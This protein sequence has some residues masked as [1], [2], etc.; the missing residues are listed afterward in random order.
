MRGA[1]S[2]GALALAAGA[3]A[4]IPDVR[5]KVDLRI[6]YRVEQDGPS[7]LRL[8]DSL[9]RVSVFALTFDLEPGLKAVTS[10]RLERLPGTGDR[11][12]FDEFYVEDAGIWRAGKQYLPFG[13]GDLLRETVLAVRGDTPLLLRNVPLTFAAFDGG[14]GRTRGVMVRAGNLLNFSVAT[15]Q[16]LAIQSTS[17][18]PV[19]LPSEAPGRGRG[20]ERAYGVSLDQPIGKGF[21]RAEYV[22]LRQGE[23]VKD[24]DRDVLDVT[25]RERQNA[26]EYWLV[27]WTRDTAPARVWVRAEGAF[28]LSREATFE[29]MI[30]VRQGRLFDLS[31]GVRFRY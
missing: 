14:P 17:L 25:F 8:Y 9:G 28:A 23:T 19:R 1:I 11:D 31:L 21:A 5:F 12:S 29:P 18:L 10:Q 22:A 20:Y 2:L 26:R 24:A 13:S 4:Q 15:G 3:N 6:V 27:G 16:F 30:R 7:S